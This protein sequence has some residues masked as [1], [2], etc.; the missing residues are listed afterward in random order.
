MKKS[1]DDR[2]IFCLMVIENLKASLPFYG[3]V[4]WDF[5]FV[6]SEVH[7]KDDHFDGK[8][9]FSKI[10]IMVR[11]TI[12]KSFFSPKKGKKWKKMEKFYGNNGKKQYFFGFFW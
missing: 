8:E 12:K 11:T 9:K 7:G 1:A 2:S 10:F 5:F 4:W 6:F 3:S